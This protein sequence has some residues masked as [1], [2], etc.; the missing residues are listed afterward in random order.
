M[1]KF[2]TPIKDLLDAR[3]HDMLDIRQLALQPAQV[4][5]APDILIRFLGFLDVSVETDEC[6]GPGSSFKL[7]SGVLGEELPGDVLEEGKGQAL[8]VHPV[9]QAHKAHPAAY[10]NTSRCALKMMRSII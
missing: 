9:A 4:M 10:R 7:F 6:V 8:G 5:L 3:L 1:L 2:I